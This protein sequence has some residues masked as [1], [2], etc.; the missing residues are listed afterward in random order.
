MPTQFFLLISLGGQFCGCGFVAS[1]GLADFRQRVVMAIAV[2]GRGISRALADGGGVFW[3]VAVALL[4][5]RILVD[6]GAFFGELGGVGLGG[7]STL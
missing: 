4:C 5:V 1:V 6:L 7:R 2:I 3:Y